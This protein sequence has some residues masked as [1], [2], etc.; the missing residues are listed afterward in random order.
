MVQAATPHSF[1]LRAILITTPVF[2]S[3]CT[4]E[5]VVTRF[6]S[7]PENAIGH[8]IR[9]R[10]DRPR[11]SNWKGFFPVKT[12][13][14]LTKLDGIVAKVTRQTFK[15]I[16]SVPEE[17]CRLQDRGTLTLSGGCVNA[18]K[19]ESLRPVFSA[20]GAGIT[21]LSLRHPGILHREARPIISYC[22]GLRSLSIEVES[23]RRSGKLRTLLASHGVELEELELHIDDCLDQ[24]LIAAIAKHCRALHRLKI[25][26]V[27]IAGPMTEIWEALGECLRHID[28]S[29]GEESKGVPLAELESIAATCKGVSHL[30][31][32]KPEPEQHASVLS[33]CA[34]Y[35]AQLEFVEL[36]GSEPDAS[37]LRSI[38]GVCPT[39]EIEMYCCDAS[40]CAGY[41]IHSIDKLLSTGMSKFARNLNL[42]HHL[43][44]FHRIGDTCPK[45]RSLSL[46]EVWATKLDFLALLERPKPLV[47]IGRNAFF[48]ALA[49]KVST[50]EI[51]SYGGHCPRPGVLH[52]FVAA[53][54]GLRSVVLK[55]SQDRLDA[56]P[57]NPMGRNGYIHSTAIRRRPCNRRRSWG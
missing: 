53:N 13:L 21:K 26:C 23:S 25:G 45:L 10:S 3:H 15:T 42:Y 5:K 9:F 27:S 31:F 19:F 39:S 24:N 30:G 52:R 51:F 41:G 46:Y 1:K 56:C 57:C 12:V 4:R 18:L 55:S 11:L 8:V 17:P 50:I 6:D 20:L 38:A 40:N 44:N 32:R 35:G 29:K 33:V 14:V 54:R 16:E 34:Q 2:L 28:L 49:K 43:E 37:F 47:S 48:E 7:L 36:Y 22:T